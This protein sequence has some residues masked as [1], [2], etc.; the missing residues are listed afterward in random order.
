VKD[1][2]A[3]T[4]PRITWLILMSTGIGYFFGA[5]GGWHLLTLFH[6]I[7]GT[8]LMASGTAA[9]NQWFEREAD[10]K[11]RRTR[12]RPLP[13]GRLPEENALLFGLLISAAG[14]FDLQLCVNPLA[15]LLGA[16]TL[17]SYLFLYT[18]LKQ[19]S[20][21]STTI[22]AIPGAMPPLIGYAAASGTLRWDAW[23]LFAILFLWQFPHFY[24]IA[25]MYRED[26]ERAGIRMLPV[27]EPDGESTARRILWFSLALI[28]ISLVPKF[29]SMT[30]NLYL[31]G[32]AAMGLLF[33]YAGL[34]I[35]FDRTRQ[36]ARRVLLA[37]VVYLP[38]LY[39][40]ML[41]DHAA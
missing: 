16:V 8:G 27:V 9:L 13:A 26:Y 41:F 20:P 38:V 29:L 37:S 34:R 32:A 31:V 6:T 35:S 19:Q 23:I 25:W 11:M 30:G 14:F 39:G 5:K 18:P 12:E 1:Y 36:Q 10:A 22:G 15:A 21:H 33:L 3:L 24:A 40:L 17:G 4:K 7:L 28:P 2:L